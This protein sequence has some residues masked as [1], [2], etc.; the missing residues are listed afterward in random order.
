MFGLFKSGP[1]AVAPVAAPVAVVHVAPGSF[2]EFFQRR[3]GIPF[4][5]IPGEIAQVALT[6]LADT[7]GDWA[8][9]LA[10]KDSGK[11]T[12]GAGFKSV[13]ATDASKIRQ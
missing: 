7:M 1:A 5:A 2:R 10:T 11:V 12:I 9:H 13:P 3:N 6:R 8:D 4:P